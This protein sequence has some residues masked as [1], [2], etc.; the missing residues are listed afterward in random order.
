MVDDWNFLLRLSIA[1]AFLTPAPVRA[2]NQPVTPTPTHKKS[3]LYT[4]DK[5]WRA[6]GTDGLLLNDPEAISAA[7]GGTLYIADTGDNRIVIWDPE[8]K[9]V[10][11]IGT[12]GQRADWRDP[13]QFNQPCGILVH[14]SGEI[15]VGDTLNHR[16]VALDKDGMVVTSWGSQ[17]TD[18][19]QFYLP[20][21][22]AKD[23]F[24]N[25][26]VLDSGNSRVQIFSPMGE[27]NSAWGSFGSDDFLLNNPLGMAVNHIDQAIVADTGNFRF[28]V[29]NDGAVPVT[30]Q[31]WYGEGPYQFK[32]PAGAA[33]TPTG[34]IAIADI[35]RVD[36]YDGD[37]GEFEYVGRWIAGRHWAGLKTGP[38]FHGITCDRLSRI[39]LT[40]VNNNWVVRL[41]PLGPT[42]PRVPRKPTPIPANISPYEGQDYPIR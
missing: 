38:K 28:E 22:V 6:D 30:Q 1:A 32:A 4:L 25:I 42:E 2:Q 23:H 12:F 11:T 31:G 40:D 21:T 14:P 29:F 13:P 26:W 9:S 35:D 34:L 16:I 15:Y 39:Y 33:V 5:I 8:R 19:G 27:F 10:K 17:G 7:P 18:N 37:D 24:G 41:R 3:T 20:R 36:F